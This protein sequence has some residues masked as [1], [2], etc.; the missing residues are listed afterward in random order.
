MT[1][2]DDEIEATV[3]SAIAK[4]FSLPAD[5]DPRLGQPPWD[6]LGHMTLVV[7]L[8]DAFGIT[9]PTH[10]I[11]ELTDVP[12]IVSAVRRWSA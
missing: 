8:E 9:F 11:A 2:S 5:G 10:A 7:A 12:A 3:R 6:S 4:T 1:R